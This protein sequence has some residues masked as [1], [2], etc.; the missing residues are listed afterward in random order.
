MACTFEPCTHLHT[1]AQ[2]KCFGTCICVNI[3]IRV[4]VYIC[5][6]VCVCGCLNYQSKRVC[7]TCGTS[8]FRWSVSRSGQCFL[9][10]AC[11]T[12]VT[13]EKFTQVADWELNTEHKYLYGMHVEHKTKGK[14]MKKKNTKPPTITATMGSEDVST[15]HFHS[16]IAEIDSQYIL[17]ASE[18]LV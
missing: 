9:A 3:C 15:I 6:G 18:M 8:T 14:Q 16:F 13:S 4:C 10:K 12:L 17:I 7:R 2:S 5:V 1:H 11:T